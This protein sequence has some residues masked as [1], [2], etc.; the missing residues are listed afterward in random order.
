MNIETIE[1][2]NPNY[3]QNL[4]GGHIKITVRDLYIFKYAD[5]LEIIAETYGLQVIDILK[6]NDLGGLYPMIG[7]ELIIPLKRS[8]N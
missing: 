3:D 4:A 6:A 7:T 2:L 8:N 1:K 5:E